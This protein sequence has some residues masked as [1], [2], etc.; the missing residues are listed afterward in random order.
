MAN[1]NFNGL[2]FFGYFS[3]GYYGAFEGLAHGIHNGELGKALNYGDSL[4]IH[5]AKKGQL[6]FFRRKNGQR[7]V[8]ARRKVTVPL[9]PVMAARSR[10]FRWQQQS[11]ADFSTFGD[12]PRSGVERVDGKSGRRLVG[13]HEGI[14]LFGRNHIVDVVE[15][16][17]AALVDNV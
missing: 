16:A 13:C 11:P 4:L 15:L 6:P 9:L 12:G 7:K 17:A 1:D 5:T 14:S 3:K 8:P 2:G 10:R